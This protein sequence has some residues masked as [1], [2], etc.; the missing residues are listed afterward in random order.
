MNAKF[1]ISAISLA[2]IGLLPQSAEARDS[3]RQCQ[4]YA[5][6]ASYVSGDGS[7][8][9][10]GALGG[11]VAGAAI[12]AILGNG[13]G[14]SIGRGA[15]VGGVT[16][17]AIGIASNGSRYDRREYNRAYWSCMNNQANDGYGFRTDS[18]VGNDYGHSYAY[19][20][21]YRGQADRVSFCMSIH[22]SFDPQTGFY[23]TNSGTYHACR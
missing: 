18:G 3:S 7:N 14:D 16:G 11:V 19:R 2:I 17:T 12:G 5:Y 21:H 9:V 8:V 13:Q 22:P 23:R 15:L 10:Q 4:D 6:R 20:H 1:A